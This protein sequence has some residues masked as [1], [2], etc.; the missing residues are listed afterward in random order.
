VTLAGGL[1]DFAGSIVTS[2]AGKVAVP[3]GVVTRAGGQE[4][5]T[6]RQRPGLWAKD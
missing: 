1:V 6:T 4:G 5:L 2:P 3:A